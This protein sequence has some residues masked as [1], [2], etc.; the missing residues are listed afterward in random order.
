MTVLA[1]NTVNWYL[2]NCKVFLLDLVLSERWGLVPP[3]FVRGSQ[4]RPHTGRISTEL[5][6]VTTPCTSPGLTGSFPSS[7]SL[8]IFKVFSLNG[9]PAV[10]W[11]Q[12]Q[13]QALPGCLPAA[14]AWTLSAV[15]KRAPLQA[16]FIHLLCFS[17]ACVAGFRVLCCLM[18][19]VWKPIHVFHLVFSCSFLLGSRV[20][21]VSV[22]PCWLEWSATQLNLTL[23]NTYQSLS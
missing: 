22:T 1:S 4:P 8:F 11:T 3:L 17:T 9:L 12:G 2:L 14:E 16:C 5:G 15:R 19:S 7:T 10:S 6:A 20:N 18:P 13:C 23:S 21:A